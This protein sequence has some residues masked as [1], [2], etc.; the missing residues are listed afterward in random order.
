MVKFYSQFWFYID[1]DG[2]I[3]AEQYQEQTSVL[4]FMHATLVKYMQR[5][6]LTLKAV[7]QL[8][9]C[10]NSLAILDSSVRLRATITYYCWKQSSS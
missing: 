8:V 3:S 2:W 10:G 7:I 4:F 5:H 1:L 6:A 9:P